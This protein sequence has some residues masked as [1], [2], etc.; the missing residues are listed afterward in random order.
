MGLN[1]SCSFCVFGFV[2]FLQAK[3]TAV[4]FPLYFQPHSLAVCFVFSSSFG[5]CNV[6]LNKIYTLSTPDASCVH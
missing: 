6:A 3:S 4:I 1:A 5:L 2:C